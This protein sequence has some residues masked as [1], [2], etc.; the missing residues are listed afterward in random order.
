MRRII[1]NDLCIENWV[2]NDSLFDSFNSFPDF[3]IGQERFQLLKTK[4]AINETTRELNNK[5]ADFYKKHNTD[6][7]IITSEANMSYHRNIEYWEEN[8]P[9]FGIAI[10]ERDFKQLGEYAIKSSIFKNKIT[11]YRIML[12]RLKNSLKI[13]QNDSQELIGEIRSVI[14]ELKN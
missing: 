14:E 1:T 10:V 5:I 13:Y 8:E 12:I 4:V 6:I 3:Q 2:T 11:W 9:W 7:S